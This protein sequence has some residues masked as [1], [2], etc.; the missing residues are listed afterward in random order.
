MGA[1]CR[2]RLASKIRLQLGTG[3]AVFRDGKLHPF[4]AN[5]DP[6][7]DQELMLDDALGKVVPALDVD[8]RP[9]RLDERMRRRLVE[10]HEIRA[11]Q[12]GGAA[13]G[14]KGSGGGKQ[15][16]GGGKGSYSDAAKRNTGKPAGGGGKGGGGG[17]RGGT[18]GGG[19]GSWRGPKGQRR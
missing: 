1:A 15:S 9:D 17:K 5:L 11:S 18:G 6:K 19:K 8:L 2:P 13:Q 4:R 3:F 16:G 10:E 12:G 14:G 7:F